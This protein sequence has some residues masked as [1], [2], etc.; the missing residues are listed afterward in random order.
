MK[1]SISLLALFLLL[2]FVQPSNAAPEPQLKA[3]VTAHSV[4]L[5]WTNNVGFTNVY[6]STTS[7]GPFT[8]LATVQT[9]GTSSYM[10]LAVTTGTTYFYYVTATCI[11]TGAVCPQGPP[12]TVGESA[13]SLTVTG[14]VPADAPVF[15]FVVTPTTLSFSGVTGQPA[16]AAQPVNV[17]DTAPAGVQTPFTVTTSQPWL[18]ATP[19]SGSTTANVNISVNI[20]GLVAGTYTGNV[21]LTSPGLS[22]SPF[23][24]PVTLVLIDPVAPPPPTG[25]S[26]IVT[27]AMSGKKV[28]VAGAWTDSKSP[29]TSYT[30]FG[31]GKV[32][33]SGNGVTNVSWKG[34]PVT[35]VFLSVCDAVGGCGVA[36]P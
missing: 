12:P 8:L 6:K 22:N 16:P 34:T 9:S 17:Q 15:T 3:T 26:I 20:T 29:T 13:H 30:L 24:I 4:K 25:L 36:H 18:V 28:T 10:D 14:T 27:E 5:T 11:P 23:T 33:K 7:A 32:L 35:P 31:G 19:T 1:R 21:I 2:S